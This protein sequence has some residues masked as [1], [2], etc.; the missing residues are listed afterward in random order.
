MYDGTVNK[1]V[2]NS[3][4]LLKHFFLSEINNQTNLLTL[5]NNKNKININKLSEKVIK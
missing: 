4:N 3:H 1:N 5:N 2:V